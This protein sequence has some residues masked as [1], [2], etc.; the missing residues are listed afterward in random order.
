METSCSFHQWIKI[1]F[2]VTRCAL[3]AMKSCNL[4]CWYPWTDYNEVLMRQSRFHDQRYECWDSYNFHQ[5]CCCDGCQL[6]AFDLAFRNKRDPT[7]THVAIFC[8]SSFVGSV[9]VHPKTGFWKWCS[10]NRE[11]S[12]CKTLLKQNPKSPGFSRS[13]RHFSL[14]IFNS[15]G[16]NRNTE[17]WPIHLQSKMLFPDHLNR[18]LYTISDMSNTSFLRPFSLPAT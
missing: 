7:I 8:C 3:F 6:M 13:I 10:G 15:L 4:L 5:C 16:S 18:C 2:P 14:S 11:T 17:N 12:L 9:R 1:I